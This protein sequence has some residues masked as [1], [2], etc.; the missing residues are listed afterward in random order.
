MARCEQLTT[1]LNTLSYDNTRLNSLV[2][3]S[4]AATATAERNSA[5]LS[6]KLSTALRALT[7]AEA[8]HKITK[9]DLSKSK[10]ALSTVRATYASETKRREAENGKFLERW[11][12]VANEQTKLGSSVG[13]GIVC[14]NLIPPLNLPQVS[15]LFPAH[16]HIT[17]D[18]TRK[19][20]IATLRFC[21]LS[22]CESD[23][24][25]RT[26]PS[27]TLLSGVLTR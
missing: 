24:S 15:A 13:A 23:L 20:I 17:D 7:D 4:N 10:I 5:A 8:A 22:R 21:S 9:E 6:S 25:R 26:T 19:T 16:G 14:A 11:G 12:K 1:R 27:R 18:F 3:S 2:A